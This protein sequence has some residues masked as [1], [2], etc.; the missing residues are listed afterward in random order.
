MVLDLHFITSLWA[1]LIWPLTKILFWMSVGLIAANFIEALNW[2]HRLASL[3]RPLVRLGR[4]SPVSGASFSMAFFSGVTANTMLAEAFDK[5]QLSKKEL[6]LANLFNGLPRFFLHLPTVFFLTAPLIKMAALLYLALTFAAAMLQTVVVVIGG[7]ILLPPLQGEL[8][9]VAPLVREKIDWHQAL[10]KS[11]QRFRKRIKGLIYFTVPV[12]IL[13]FY[14]GKHGVFDW[15]EQVFATKVWFLAWLQPQSLGIV[16]A[17]VTVEFSAGLAAAGALLAAKS[18]SYKEVVLALLV[19]NILSTPIRA[20]RHQFP[21]YVGIFSPKLA[22][23]LVGV[24][25]VL[26][27]ASVIA[28]GLGY[29][30]L[31]LG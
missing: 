15:L 1:H 4:L 29:Y 12:Y 13:F 9:E 11:V 27:L 7:R 23:E 10:K 19:G 30:F 28:V 21:Y 5:G 16:M 17:H 2:T 14:L 6:V 8:G 24:S 20:V 22:L 18:L 31:P 25:Q 3:T 26:R